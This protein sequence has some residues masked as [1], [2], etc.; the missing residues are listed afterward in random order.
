MPKAIVY[1]IK[2]A[3]PFFSKK[4]TTKKFPANKICFLNLTA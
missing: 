1:L 3:A 4:F 2:P